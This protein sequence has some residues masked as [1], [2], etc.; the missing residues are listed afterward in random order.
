MVY[1]IIGLFSLICIFLAIYAIRIYKEDKH[2]RTE[3]KRILE[4]EEEDRIRKML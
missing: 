4:E 1:V 2:I 3:S